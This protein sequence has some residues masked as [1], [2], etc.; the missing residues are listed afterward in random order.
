MTDLLQVSSVAATAL[1]VSAEASSRVEVASDSS[2]LELRVSTVASV[3][4]VEVESTAPAPTFDVCTTNSTGN[5]L[6]ITYDYNADG[7]VDEADTA[8]HAD[9]SAEVDWSADTKEP[10]GFVNR[11]DST[12]AFTDGTRTFAITGTYDIYL[13]GVKTAKTGDSVVITDTVGLWFIYYS[14]AG[15]LTASQTAWDFTGGACPVATVYWNGTNGLIGDERHGI[16]MDGATHDVLHHTVGARYNSG[17]AGTFSD[18]SF[19]I[20]AGDIYDEDIKIDIAEQTQCRVFYKNGSASYTFSSKGTLYYYTDGGKIYYNNGNTLTVADDNKYVA[21][22][23][24]ACND[25]A[26]PIYVLMGQR[27]DTTLAQASAN[28]KYESLSLGTLPSAEMKLLYRVIL[29]N[30]ATP[31]ESVQDL[32]SVSNLPAGNYVAS[33]HGALTGLTDDDHT[34]YILHSLATAENDFLVASGSGAF[35]KK[36]LAEVQ[37]L[38]GASAS[39]VKAF[40]R[41]VGNASTDLSATYARVGTTVTVTYNSHGFVAGDYVYLNFTSGSSGTPSDGGFVVVSA[42]VNTFIVTHGS[43]GNT[44]GN[45]TIEGVTMVGASGVKFIADRG[46]GSYAVNFSTAFADTNYVPVITTVGAYFSD[47]DEQ[48]YVVT[49]LT[50]AT[51][52]IL[53][54]TKTNGTNR[55]ADHVS[56]AVFGA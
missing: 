12:I 9:A 49:D 46:T 31:Y 32:R 39:P 33:D 23:V 28:N 18:D 5:M 56:V 43:S 13:S 52:Y 26:C 25:P 55:D 44:A 37:A 50:L 47:P 51:N 20:T 45:V 53:F 7:K 11:T 29:R 48:A 27:Q 19:T 22:W 14:T 2:A 3:G 6:Q 36:T 24:F 8:D 38:V 16:N 35:V 1:T 30:D 40:V 21:Y 15:V 34:Q 17:L 54:Q 42:D 41:F 10:T 4:L